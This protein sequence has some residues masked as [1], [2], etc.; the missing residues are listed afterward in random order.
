MATAY[1]IRYG[2]AK[3]ELGIAAGT[4]RSVG[5][6]GDCGRDGSLVKDEGSVAGGSMMDDGCV[7]TTGSGRSG[8]SESAVEVS[9]VI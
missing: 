6:G 2:S 5:F 8:M 1:I 9:M 3:T 7:G 4:S